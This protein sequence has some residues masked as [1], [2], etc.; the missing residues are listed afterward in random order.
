MNALTSILCLLLLASTPGDGR[1]R[2]A[3][4]AQIVA[5]DARD[6]AGGA[7]FL[8]WP[9]SPS[10]SDQWDYVV[11]AADEKD[12]EFKPV[13]R[14]PSTSPARLRS[15]F[16]M[17][18]GFSKRNQTWRATRVLRLDVGCSDELK[19]LKARAAALAALADA[20][21]KYA[22]AKAAAKTKADAE[23]SRAL[24]RMVE[25]RCQTLLSLRPDEIGDGRRA[26]LR[27]DRARRKLAERI[28]R[29]K[30]RDQ[31]RPCWFKL[32]AAPRGAKSPGRPFP[33]LLASAAA[34]PNWFK[35]S[36]MNAFLSMLFLSA[37]ILGSIA[38]ASRRELFLRK[39]AGLDAVEEALGR[40]TE[41]G[42][43]AL[44]VH[45]LSGVS[46]IAVIAA[47]NILG[48]MARRVAEYDTPLLVVNNDPVVY[49]LSAE[50]VREG[51][52]EAGRPDR[53]R[54]D[55]I[56][57]VASEQFPY[58]AAVAGIMARERPAANFF[59]GY[60]YAESLI[61]AEAG[62]ATGAIQIAATDAFTQLPFFVT[63]CDYTLMGEELYAAS[64]YLSR[65]R[66]LMGTLRGQDIGKAALIAA[67]VLGL[68]L[69]SAGAT[70][71]RDL[72]Q[73]F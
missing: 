34:R 49:S 56:F 70:W 73:T 9:R 22:E 59:M 35:W 58:V 13:Q 26:L 30:R 60:F 7:L 8:T 2:F 36:A 29:V 17:Q 6:D 24:V 51:Y 66:K 19:R 46:S 64:A 48:R 20:L 71:F 28:R 14:F 67:L 37:V 32:G 50:V 38:A 65:E 40:C 15:A 54:E 31:A 69:V 25:Q 27:L 52:M 43:P 21:P 53:F 33:G 11:W 45:G 1:A 55:H 5:L 47:V 44:F 68:V 23:K 3:P 72:F 42:K 41:M 10:E 61:L 16:P 63:T 12:G 4:P 18:F 57:M 39:I 62:A